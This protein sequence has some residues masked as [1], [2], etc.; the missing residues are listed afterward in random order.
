MKP[1]EQL[2]LEERVYRFI[3]DPDNPRRLYTIYIYASAREMRGI[4]GNTLRRLLGVKRWGELPHLIHY[5]KPEAR[6]LSPS[7]D[8]YATEEE[9]E[10][11]HNA[12]ERESRAAGFAHA[13]IEIVTQ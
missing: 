6:D 11:L 9:L 12:I 4:I 10:V 3:M 1:W 8:L 7:Y 2:G 13:P 5:N